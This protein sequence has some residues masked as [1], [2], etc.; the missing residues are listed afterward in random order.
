[1][2]WKIDR[3]TPDLT[4]PFPMLSEMFIE[5]GDKEDW[6]ILHGLHYKSDGALMGPRFYKV[7]TESSLVGVCVMTYPRGLLKGRHLAFPKIKPGSGE[8]KL[9]NTYR[10]KLL[11]KEFGLNARTVNDTMF[12]GVGVGYRMLNLAARMD[13]RRYCEIQSSMSRFNMFA[14]R[15]G[16][17]FV[18][19]SEAE[20]AQEA[21]ALYACWFE[22]NCADIVGLREEFESMPE[23]K[24]AAAL[25]DL[26]DF[27][28]RHSAQEKTGKNRFKGTE[29]VDAMQPVEVFKNLNQLC[30]ATPQYGVYKN[31]DYERELPERIP[32]I[33]FDWQSPSEPLR[34]F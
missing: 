12:R 32:L 21:R 26:K 17:K 15:A 33:A 20:S 7:T 25:K 6:E 10:Y 28:Y 31:P 34:E 29:R 16:F 4:K 11:N 9:T 24:S 8:T 23:W 30:F 18:T 3:S 2:T 22:T 5:R 13:G 14:H 27:Y 19:I 1:M